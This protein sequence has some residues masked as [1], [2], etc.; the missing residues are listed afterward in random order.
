MTLK[1]CFFFIY[2]FILTL[3]SNIFFKSIFDFVKRIILSIPYDS[4]D[5]FPFMTTTKNYIPVSVNNKLIF[6]SYLGFI[7]L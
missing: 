7:T 4:Y 5:D 2:L 1:I 3:H 6:S